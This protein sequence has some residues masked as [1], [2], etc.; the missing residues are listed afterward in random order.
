MQK[1][2]QSSNSTYHPRM[3]EQIKHFMIDMDGV[4]WTGETPMAGL[5]DFFDLL[6]QHGY[7]FLLV[8]NNASKTPSQYVEKLGKFGVTITEEHV[9][10]SALATADFCASEFAA[11]T[12]VYISG[13]AGIK[14]A[15]RQRGFKLL[16]VDDVLAG[17]T[18]PLVVVGFS[19]DTGYYDLAAATI[20]VNK[21]AR[22]IGT[23]PDTTFPSEIGQ[24]PGAGSLI[25]LVEIA[26]E[27]TAFKVGKPGQQMFLEGLKRL[28]AAPENTAM[29]GDRLNTDIAGG[30]SVGMH[31]ILVLSGIA[32][33]DE[34]KES[35]VQ[36]SFVFDDIR[37]IAAQINTIH[38]A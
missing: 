13:G 2:D 11:E 17:A 36:P 21:G 30:H 19:R 28:G 37:A 4:L 23:N 7:P 32:Q 16:T 27:Q 35:T 9:L 24:L 26:T 3:F 6:N 1:F 8:T 25:G 29:I 33:Q 5:V 10:T 31:T 15:M 12:A 20:L 18:A 34:L 22:F 38:N 14:E